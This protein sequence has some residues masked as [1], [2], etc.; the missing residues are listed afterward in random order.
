MSAN[1]NQHMLSW[2]NGDD[3]YVFINTY[4]PSQITMQPQMKSI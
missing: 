4:I 2:N 1:L 3:N